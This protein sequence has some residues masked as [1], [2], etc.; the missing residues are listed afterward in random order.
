MGNKIKNFLEKGLFGNKNN[1]N[2]NSKSQQSNAFKLRNSLSEVAK[3]NKMPGEDVRTKLHNINNK[4]YKGKKDPF[5]KMIEKG[6]I[7][8]PLTLNGDPPKTL[9]T[10]DATAHRENVIDAMLKNRKTDDQ[11]NV[12]L[13]GYEKTRHQGSGLPVNPNIIENMQAR[14]YTPGFARGAKILG[15]E[16]GLSGKALE[17]FE[18]QVLNDAVDQAT[19]YNLASRGYNFLD[20]GNIER[21]ESG[22]ATFKAG[23]SEYRQKFE[24]GKSMFAKKLDTGD[25]T[26][27]SDFNSKK[28]DIIKDKDGNKFESS[29]F[30][31]TWASDISSE[32]KKRFQK[33]YRDSSIYQ[34]L[35]NKYGF[36]SADNQFSKL[37]YAPSNS[38]NNIG[39]MRFKS[40]IPYTSTKEWMKTGRLQRSTKPSNSMFSNLSIE[41]NK[42]YQDRIKARKAN[43][44]PSATVSP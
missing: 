15:K 31:P 32:N 6:L 18:E 24:D 29:G 44:L 22:I 20:K 14:I 5:S 19:N 17:K 40:E 36:T 42:A 7:N 16:R 13:E 39:Q 25:Y 33:A 10:A 27:F 1:Y 37:D 3:S 30:N 9:P 41:T 2:Q 4:D 38:E 34:A 21:D 28:G 8:S 11:G 35:S 26:K 23:G 43:T 12:Y